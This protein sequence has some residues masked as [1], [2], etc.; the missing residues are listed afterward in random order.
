MFANK[1]KNTF[2]LALVPVLVSSMFFISSCKKNNDGDDDDD[3]ASDTENPVIT[4]TSPTDMQV[5]A[6]GDTVWL[7][8]L[9]TDKSLHELSITLKNDKDGSVL[10]SQTP[11][12]HDFTSYTINAF[13]K[14]VVTEKTNATL[15]ISATDHHPNTATKTIAI[16]LN[17]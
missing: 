11:T 12:V 16:T 17:P 7:K 15:T 10:Y 9:V 14:S 3:G 2:L 1:A 8:G 13:W 5:Y 6:L 4:M